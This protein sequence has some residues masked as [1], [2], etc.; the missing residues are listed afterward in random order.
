MSL[1]LFNAKAIQTLTH[2]AMLSG[3]HY[4]LGA[5]IPLT[6]PL[7]GLHGRSVDCSGFVRWLTYQS[8]DN[9]LVIPDGSY[10]QRDWF[11]QRATKVEYHSV[12]QNLNELH[13]AFICP[14]PEHKVGHVWF[15][16]EG[17]T[18][19]SHGGVG[20]NS[21]RWDTRILTEEVCACYILPHVWK[22]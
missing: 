7:S 8:T 5:K 13:I 2:R 4:G 3:M 20:P 18:Y 16:R 6:T 10:Y 22:D 19:E 9:H 1:P 21:R 11:A 17:W 12:G 14:T 15:V